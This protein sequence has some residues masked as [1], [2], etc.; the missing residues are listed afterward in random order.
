MSRVTN[1]Q[2]ESNPVKRCH[3]QEKFFKL[4]DPI[5][6]G[7]L[8]AQGA[9]SRVKFSPTGLLQP[10]YGNIRAVYK[11]WKQPVGSGLDA[12]LIHELH[13]LIQKTPR[14]ALIDE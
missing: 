2:S 10:Y 5:T 1:H 3:V 11:L 13:G 8:H 6:V 7:E 12:D 14:F 4:A 9:L